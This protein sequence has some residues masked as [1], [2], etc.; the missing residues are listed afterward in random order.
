MSWDFDEEE[1]VQE[2]MLKEEKRKREERSAGKRSFWLV[3]I[4][5]W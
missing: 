3:W 4:G 2:L 1:Y 5:G